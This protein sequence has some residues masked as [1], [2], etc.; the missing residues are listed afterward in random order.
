MDKR[1]CSALLF[2]TALACVV[3][4]WGPAAIAAPSCN[5]QPPP[6]FNN[7]GNGECTP[8]KAATSQCTSFTDPSSGITYTVEILPDSSGNWPILH[9][10]DTTEP[11]YP[12]NLQNSK[13]F[14][15]RISRN[16]CTS[17]VTPSFT[18]AVPLCAGSSSYILAGGKFLT[19]PVCSLNSSSSQVL[20]QVSLNTMAADVPS[21]DFSIFG[22]IFDNYSAGLDTGTSCASLAAIQPTGPAGSCGTG[23]IRGPGC[24]N[25]YSSETGIIY[26]SSDQLTEVD[27]QYDPCSN[28]VW[29]VSD[30]PP[31]TSV[32]WS[33]KQPIWICEGTATGSP[34]QPVSSFGAAAG[35][36][37]D[38][39]PQGTPL[40]ARVSYFC[41]GD[42]CYY[43]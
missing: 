31:N 10:N 28:E 39:Q 25:T 8:D 42:V 13:E 16:V 43:R 38:L 23:T 36:F 6:E 24:P 1:I 2:A 15:Y 21:E 37:L 7:L 18:L 14:R 19:G 26:K 4:C 35:V 22:S 17:A 3:L 29:K 30:P 33:S 41:A 40:P 34:C 11:L 5:A 32:I 20:Y 12:V 9:N 27:V